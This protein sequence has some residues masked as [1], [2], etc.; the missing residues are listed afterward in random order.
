[1]RDLVLVDLRQFAVDD[2]APLRSAPALRAVN[3]GL[4]SIRKNDAGQTLL[5]LPRVSAPDDWRDD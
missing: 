2:L 3:L 1:L 5:G 4:G